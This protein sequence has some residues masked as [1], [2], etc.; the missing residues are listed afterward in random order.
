VTDET[1]LR[2]FFDGELNDDPSSFFYVVT[3]RPSAE[4]ADRLLNRALGKAKESV[5]VSGPDGGPVQIRNFY[6]VAK[7]DAHV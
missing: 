2:R 6:A 4:A 5:E 1:T 7:P 3:E